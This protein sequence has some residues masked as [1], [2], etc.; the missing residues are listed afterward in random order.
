MLQNFGGNITLY[1]RMRHVAADPSIAL[2][3]PE[4]KKMVG[5]GLTPEGIEQNPALYGLMLEN[6]WRDKPIDAEAW[7]KDYALRRYGKSNAQIDK[8]WENS[9]NT[10]YS[11]A[12]GHG[13]PASIIVGRPTTD[14]S[15]DRGWTR[16]CT[17]TR[18]S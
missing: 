14:M 4:S 12:A 13:G 7:L 9:L 15:F 18:R 17:M 8:A 2:H 6:V 1:G 16:N 5:I 3:D 11:G 10:V